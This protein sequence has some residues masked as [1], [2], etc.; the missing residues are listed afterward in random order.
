MNVFLWLAS[1]AVIII[2]RKLGI[3]PDDMTGALI[4]F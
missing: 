3:L 1:C 2:S 4:G